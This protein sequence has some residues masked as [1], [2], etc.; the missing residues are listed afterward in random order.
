MSYLQYT[1]QATP[2]W[3]VNHPRN[4]L[5]W[6]EDGDKCRYSYLNWNDDGSERF[7]ASYSFD[8]E[9]SYNTWS[10]KGL[11]YTKRGPRPFDDWIGNVGLITRPFDFALQAPGLSA[12]AQPNLALLK[13]D[14][15]WERLAK[16]AAVIGTQRYQ[17]RSCTVV[18][19]NHGIY[20]T[21]NIV[22]P[23]NIP[24]YFVVYFDAE[25]S[26]PIAWKQYDEQNHLI[27]T[28]DVTTEQTIPLPGGGCYVAP[29]HVVHVFFEFQDPK[30]I[31]SQLNVWTFDYIDVH[32]TPDPGEK[33]RLDLAKAHWINDEDSHSGGPPPR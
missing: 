1:V 15:L 13:S 6:R 12:A 11:Y 20:R 27:D 23:V 3:E 17:N 22:P 9:R 24:T 8:G 14:P 26:M 19:I 30:L 18:R 7:E 4:Q 21:S 29:K 25:S 28:L 2:V 16:E 5:T 10:G 33:F 31:G 32:T